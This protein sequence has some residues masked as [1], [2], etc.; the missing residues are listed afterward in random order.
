MTTSKEG[1]QVGIG[2]INLNRSRTSDTSSI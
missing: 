2:G 1:S